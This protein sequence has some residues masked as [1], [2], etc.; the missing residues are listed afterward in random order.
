M[1]RC[2]RC[3]GL[4][5][6]EV[7]HHGVALVVLD[8]FVHVAVE[9]CG[10][11]QRLALSRH[12]IEQFAHVV[13]EAEVGE[14][15]GLVDHAHLNRIERYLAAAHVV[16]QSARAGDDDGCTHTE[17]VELRPV[18]GA[19]VDGED[20]ATALLAHGEQVETNLLGELASGHEHNARGVER[21]GLADASEHRDAER[22]R[23]SGAG[24]GATAQVLAGECLGNAG[25][26]DLER[27]VDVVGGE[28]RAKVS[29]D[30]EGAKPCG[31]RGGGLG[32]DGF[33]FHKRTISG[34]LWAPPT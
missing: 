18:G 26:L 32:H 21:L 5:A 25:G 3:V 22:K 24:C 6:D 28:C 29:R 30:T 10:E 1:V 23:L 11:Q 7:H 20:V 16:E 31:S 33:L 2:W 13:H 8:Q 34:M 17:R 14:A 4:L 9:R 15:V 12:G 19:A 27:L